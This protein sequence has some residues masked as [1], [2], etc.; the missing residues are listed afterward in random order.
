MKFQKNVIA[1]LNKC[2][3]IA[4]LT[5]QGNPCF[6]VAAEKQDPCLLFDME[7]RLLTTVFEEPGG[8]MSMVP[9]P[10]EEGAFLATHR[11]YSPNDS[12]NA[13]IVRVYPGQDGFQVQTLARLPFVH[14]FDILTR[15]HIHYLIACT[16]KSGHQYKDD[17]SSPGKVY[18][19]VLPEDLSAVTEEHPLKLTVLKDH[20]LKNH[21]YYRI[22]KD[23]YDSALVSSD[24]GVFLFT[25]PETPEGEFSITQLLGTPASDAVLVDLDGDGEEELFVFSPFHGDQ[26]LIYKKEHGSYFLQYTH[27]VKTEFTHALW[28]G[29]LNGRKVVLAGHRKGKRELLLFSYSSE[30]AH[31]TYEVVDTDC[32]PANVSC[33]ST[34]KGPRIIAANREINEIA[35]YLPI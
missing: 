6:L 8:V 1:T 4:P 11:F 35:M 17:W 22:T 3:S 7:G 19:T 9:L 13:S 30:T 12:A 2:Y 23:G 21:G 31:Y 20:M 32:G 16:L 14:R 29:S 28:A 15:N 10:W 25:P 27:P 5:Y 34:D 26:I 33:F 24:E 18:A